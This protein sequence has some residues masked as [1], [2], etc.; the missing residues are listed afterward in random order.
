MSQLKKKMFSWLVLG[1]PKILLVQG[2]PSHLTEEPQRTF[3]PTQC[4]R[5]TDP[6]EKCKNKNIF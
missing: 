1:W 2:F 3:W 4:Y 5:A 6:Q